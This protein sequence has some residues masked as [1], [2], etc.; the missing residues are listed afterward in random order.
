[1]SSSRA[2][3]QADRQFALAREAGREKKVRHVGTGDEQDE[4]HRAKQNP[5]GRPDVPHDDLVV[6]ADVDS[7][8]VAELLREVLSE[9]PHGCCGLER[10]DPGLEP[11]EGG[12]EVVA[13]GGGIEGSLQ[14]NEDLPLAVAEVFGHHADHL[15]GLPVEAEGL[16]HDAGVG[17]QARGPEGMAED[18]D[19]GLAGLVLGLGVPASKPR[20]HPEDVDQ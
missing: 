8:V 18:H 19:P 20:P 16:S 6:G 4:E 12:E 5:Q 7:V 9:S 14:G 13:A 15:V 17:A 3:G 1:M 11:G 2:K 10:R